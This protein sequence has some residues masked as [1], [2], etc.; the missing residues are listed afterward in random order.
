MCSTYTVIQKCTISSCFYYFPYLPA[1][2]EELPWQSNKALHCWGYTP[3]FNSNS[4]WHMQNFL[5]L[6]KSI[7]ICQAWVSEKSLSFW[8]VSSKPSIFMGNLDFWSKA[9]F[10][11]KSKIL[12][13]SSFWSSR[14]HGCP[15][16]AR[17]YNGPYAKKY[18][19]FTTLFRYFS[20]TKI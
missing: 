18:L 5:R 16:P 7:F 15:D 11:L 8:Q 9:K 19:D 4:I 13:F 20:K 6:S 12:Y 3:V 2:H 14:I 1:L 10:Y 17:C